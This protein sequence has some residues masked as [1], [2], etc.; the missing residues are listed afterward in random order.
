MRILKT[1]KR[2]PGGLMMVP[3]ILAAVINTFTPDIMKIGSFTTA[4]FSAQGSATII[5]ICL[6]CLGTNFKIRDIKECFKRGSVLLAAK[7]LSGAI[8]GIILNAYFGFDGILGISTIAIVG[9]ATNSNNNLYLTLVSEYGD[10]KDL[11]AQNILNFN[12]GAFFTLIILG[13]GGKANISIISFISVMGPFLVGMLIG[14]IDEEIGAFFKPGITMI[15]PLMGF[16][17]GAS[18]NLQN[19]VKAGLG[20]VLLGLIVLIGTG[21]P[22]V[23]IDKV[24]NKRPGYAGAAL[25]SVAGNAIATPSALALL[26]NRFQIYV[27][28][29]TTQI[30]AAVIIT[31]ILTPLFTMYVNRNWR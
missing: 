27:E 20:G 26:D 16:C 24:I 21:I 6:F 23:V 31:I 7:V 4:L 30:A 15:I 10:E 17:I 11:A 8:I 14:N 25:S 12:T 3:L 22:L 9:A 18:I 29:A 2:V 28:S 1:I 13:I 19:V 5:G